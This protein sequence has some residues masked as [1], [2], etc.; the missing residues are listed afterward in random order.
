MTKQHD[1]KFKLD[2]IQYYEDHKNLGIHGC[3]EN[4]G[5]GYSTLVKSFDWINFDALK[6]IDEECRELYKA[7]PF[8]DEQRCD[9]LC[10][11]LKQ[12]IE[13]LE[14]IALKQNISHNIGLSQNV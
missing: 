8:I 14:Q 10:N 7:S 1:K 11:A 4:L 2:A 9:T 5:I 13:M 12:R 3:A 6:D